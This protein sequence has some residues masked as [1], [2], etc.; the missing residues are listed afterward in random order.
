MQAIYGRHGEAPLVVLAPKS[1]SHCFEIAQV[2]VHIAIKYMT[3]VMILLMQKLI[4]IYV[5]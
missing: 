5:L 2:A 1:P 3:P 4:L